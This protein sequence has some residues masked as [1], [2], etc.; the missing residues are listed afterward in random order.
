[1]MDRMPKSPQ[2]SPIPA[3]LPESS[4]VTAKI[5]SLKAGEEK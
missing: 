3:T 4:S 2:P 5:P 1:M